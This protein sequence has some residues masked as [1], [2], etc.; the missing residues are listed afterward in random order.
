MAPAQEAGSGVKQ[1]HFQQRRGKGWGSPPAALFERVL[2]EPKQTSAIAA[3]PVSILFPG[4]Q[5]SHRCHVAQNEASKAELR[6][7]LWREPGDTFTVES[8]R[9]RYF[10]VPGACFLPSICHAVL[11]FPWYF[12]PRRKVAC[13]SWFKLSLVCGG[14]MCFG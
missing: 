9:F 8:F 6:F 7:H 3:G 12:N 10:M 13:W 14:G 5:Q 1:S 11:F 4:A 2:G